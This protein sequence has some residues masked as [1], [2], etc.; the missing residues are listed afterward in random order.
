M[1]YILTSFILII[2]FNQNYFCQKELIEYIPSHQ[3]FVVTVNGESLFKKIP[4][5]DL[6]NL[7]I[8]K[9]IIE[10]INEQLNED[11][12][13]HFYYTQRE[14]FGLSLLF[15]GEEFGIDNSTKSYYISSGTDS[16]NYNGF[17]FRQKNHETFVSFLKNIISEEEYDNNIVTKNGYQYFHKN[18]Y[19][20]A[21]NKDVVFILNFSE[22][23]GALYALE[24]VLAVEEDE[25]YY[26]NYE[27][28][29]KDI[30][31]KREITIQKKLESAFE[32]F[33]NEDPQ[34]SLKHNVQYNKTIETPHDISYYINGIGNSFSSG[35]NAFLMGSNGANNIMSMFNDNYSYAS[36]V[37]DE[38]EIAITSN[39]H[40]SDKF[41]E[42]M[43]ALN[44][45]KFNKKL[46]K[47]IDGSNLVGIMGIAV[48]PNAS[49]DIISDTYSTILKNSIGEEGAIASE[50]FFT[51]LDEEEIFDLVKGDMIFAVTDIKEFDI[52]YTSYEYDEDYNRLETTKTKKETLPEYVFTANV[53]NSDLSDK[54]I[55][56]METS[57]TVY[58]KGGFYKYTPY[59]YYGRNSGGMEVFFAIQD[60][61]LIITNDYELV[62]QQLVDGVSKDN[63]IEKQVTAMAKK[64]NLFG[65]W[66][67][68]KTIEKLDKGFGK[69]LKD[70]D[71]VMSNLQNT[72]GNITIEGVKQNGN[73]F[74]TK[75]SIK[76]KENNVNSLIDVVHFANKLYLLK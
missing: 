64:N 48:N 35:F 57:K 42:N 7:E 3:N 59:S 60:N 61:V 72:F 69:E 8:Y 58:D 29:Q 23:Y 73:N 40:V 74:E 38:N 66:D 43:K 11:E 56:L 75:V 70:F 63:K 54:I 28:R 24:E 50:I 41:L 27:D 10:E 25:S 2:F 31:K 13:D 16:I 49:Y 67:N 15:M 17:L 1:R 5:S 4:K 39:Q 47:Y 44:S 68:S 46:F 19:T 12:D 30:Q 45:A 6:Q 26:E 37:F 34:L 21:W 65:F 9:G 32:T 51:L 33:F 62:T 52:S 76:T 53:G 71:Q 22:N 36:L 20:I 14:E 55:R 18:N